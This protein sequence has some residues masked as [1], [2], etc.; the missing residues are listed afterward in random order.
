LY[1]S[2]NFTGGASAS[3]VMAA[4][5][6]IADAPDDTVDAAHR[7]GMAESRLGPLFDVMLRDLQLLSGTSF[8]SALSECEATLQEVHRDL[9]SVCA[10]QRSVHQ[11]E[12]HDGRQWARQGASPLKVT[13]MCG[14][15]DM[16]CNICI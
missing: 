16:H 13:A 3:S 8:N 7:Y 2:V 5:A 14:D 9:L 12:R 11:H 4:N 1:D 10:R 6:R 15:G